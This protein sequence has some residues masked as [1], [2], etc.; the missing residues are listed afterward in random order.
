MLISRIPFPSSHSLILPPAPDQILDTDGSR[1][2]V[3]G[4]GKPRNSQGTRLRRRPERSQP[5]N[6]YLSEY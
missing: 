6:P 2:M 4:V 5:E 3:A 1:R